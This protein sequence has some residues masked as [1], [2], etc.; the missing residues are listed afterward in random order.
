MSGRQAMKSLR[1]RPREDRRL[2]AG[3]PWIYSNEID[4]RATPLKA[5]EPGELA[6]VTD[7]RGCA[8][9]I[10][11]V[12]P[13]TLIAARVLT[14]HAD[15]RIDR[16]FFVTRLA[17]ALRLR[18][19]CLGRPFYRWV[20]GEADALPGLVIDRYGDHLSMQINTAGMERLR[21][22]L[23]DAIEAVVPA[24][25]IVLRNDAPARA[26]E[27][28][29]AGIETLGAVPET[30]EVEE[31]GARFVTSL[32]RGQKTGWF[33]DQ[34]DNRRRLS[35]YVHGLRVLDL[36]G[37]AGAWSVQALRHGALEAVCVDSS[38]QALDLAQANAE[39]NGLADRLTLIEGDAF[40]V[41]REL[42][43]AGERF[44]LVICDPPAFIKRR[45]DRKPGIE[46]YVRLN[47]QALR[48][49]SEEGF[50]ITCSCSHHLALEDFRQ[51][52]RRAA[53]GAGRRVQ[54]LETGH[55][56]LDHP[57]HPAIPETDYLKALF[58]RVTG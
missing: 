37:Y 3:H 16:D 28:L 22:L 29:P 47:R 15:A 30:V 31:D 50:L 38:A 53:S 14:R 35:R 24:K 48:L 26:L 32:C 58:L 56:S 41:L 19:H 46:A 57:V 8:L 43:E 7:A 4:T 45:R 18:E 17:R 13:H 51:V 9:G 12:N 20:H 52:V 40:D 11:Y 10:A 54:I 21:S 49:V 1:L 55:Q 27:G 6:V 36:F 44:D 39:R 2:R 42:R 33:Y 5:F 23:L 34:V 25:G